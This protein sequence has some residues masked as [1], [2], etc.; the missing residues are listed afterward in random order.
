MNQFEGDTPNTPAANEE[1]RAS[2][3]LGD[4][5]SRK[6]T[7]LEEQIPSHL[8]EKAEGIRRAGDSRDLDALVSYAI[9]EGGFLRDDLRQLA[10]VWNIPPLDEAELMN[11][12]GPILLQ[13]NQGRQHEALT[14]WKELPQHRDEDQ[15]Q[16]DVNRSFVYY[17]DGKLSDLSA[18]A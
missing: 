7:P 6:S 18:T 4:S 2:S 16:L 5:V 17:P 11:K 3:V 9:S 1:S 14:A 8:V 12:L 13:C 15:V 10:C